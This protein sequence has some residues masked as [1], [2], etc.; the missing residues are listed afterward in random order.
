VVHNLCRTHTWSF[1]LATSRRSLQATDLLLSFRL[2]EAPSQQRE[3]T[4]KHRSL[5]NG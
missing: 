2:P 1:V 5:W 4:K 3:I